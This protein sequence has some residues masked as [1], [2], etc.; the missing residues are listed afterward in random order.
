MLLVEVAVNEEVSMQSLSWRI[1]RRRVQAGG[2]V[3]DWSFG[4]L[5][6]WRGKGFWWGPGHDGKMVLVV[7]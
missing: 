7:D 6:Q 3:V 2:V 4:L 1:S 5:V